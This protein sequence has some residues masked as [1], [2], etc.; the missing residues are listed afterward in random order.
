MIVHKINAILIDAIIS[1]IVLSTSITFQFF[2]FWLSMA[3]LRTGT[4]GFTHKLPAP[5]VFQQGDKVITPL[6]CS[7]LLNKKKETE[8]GNTYIPVMGIIVN[9]PEEPDGVYTINIV[10][11]LATKMSPLR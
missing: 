10:G 4:R 7:M 8:W 3:K 11:N 5:G 9:V 1:P 6:H 2:F